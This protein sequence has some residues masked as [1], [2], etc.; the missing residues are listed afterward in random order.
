M[1]NCIVQ[2]DV[3]DKEGREILDSSYEVASPLELQPDLTGTSSSRIPVIDDGARIISHV[4]LANE[5]NERLWKAFK[6][7]RELLATLKLYFEE[8]SKEWLWVAH[9]LAGVAALLGLRK[10]ALDL[11]ETVIKGRRK[12]LGPDHYLTVKSERYAVALAD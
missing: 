5:S 7:Y 3:L 1:W 8:D 6:L 2:A 4:A 9:R 10:E 12:I 11:Y